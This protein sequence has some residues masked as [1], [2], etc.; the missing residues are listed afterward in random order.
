MT[1][2]AATGVWNAWGII[3]ELKKAQELLGRLHDRQELLDTLPDDAPAQIQLLTQ[4]LEAEASE[5]H[6]RISRGVAS[7]RC[8]G[9]GA[10]GGRSR[11]PG[12]LASSDWCSSGVVD[13]AADAPTERVNF[14]AALT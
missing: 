12:A 8:P 3:S 14:D 6:G 9:R 4:V 7:A 13:A 10:A 2:I 11:S 5:L 1:E